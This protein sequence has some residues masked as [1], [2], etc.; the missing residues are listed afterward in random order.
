MSGVDELVAKYRVEQSRY[1]YY[2]IALC[3]ASIGFA[4]SQTM[5]R[6]LNNSLWPLGLS[7]FLFAFSAFSGLK[8]IRKIIGG[9]ATE[10][11]IRQIRIGENLTLNNILTS[12]DISSESQE[13]K[14]I[15]INAISATLTDKAKS[16]KMWHAWQQRTFFMAI[17]T[18]LVW[19]VYEMYLL[20]I[21]FP[22]P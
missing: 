18:F 19:R 4:V 9:I 22:A 12:M 6:P 3:V 5:G 16:L 1:A 15:A 17:I 14:D 10:I 13:A 11:D 7:V 8:F 2:L 20:S 21:T